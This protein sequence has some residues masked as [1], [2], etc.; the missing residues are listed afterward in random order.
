MVNVTCCGNQDRNTEASETHPKRPP[1]D[2]RNCYKRNEFNWN[3]CGTQRENACN[4]FGGC[5][6]CVADE[7]GGYCKTDDG[8][9]HI[10]RG[11]SFIPLEGENL[12]NRLRQGG[13]DRSDN[14]RIRRRERDVER[15][16]QNRIREMQ[17]MGQ[18]PLPQRSRSV[19]VSQS[20][21]QTQSP[22]PPTQSFVG[23]YINLF[24]LGLGLL[25][26]ISSFGL[27]HIKKI[28]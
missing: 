12:I 26:V 27:E 16:M 3:D 13:N 1:N 4:G 22:S 21:S 11:D 20:Q 6:G 25:L 5:S 9:I 17:I 28:K 2:T 10:A 23:S 18:D 24:I 19:D 14:L 15:K 7:M 8:R